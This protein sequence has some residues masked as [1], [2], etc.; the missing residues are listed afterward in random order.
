MNPRTAENHEAGNRPTSIIGSATVAS[1]QAGERAPSTIVAGVPNRAVAQAGPVV[2]TFAATG[3]R[4]LGYVA[5]GLLLALVAGGVVADPGANRGL[6]LIC[7]AGVLLTWVALVRPQVAAHAHGLLLRNMVRDTYIPWSAIERCKV[8]QTL[9]VVT[10]RRQFH[11]LG[12]SRSARSMVRGDQPAR[13]AQL[14]GSGGA[15]FL[16]SGGAA[17]DKAPN[18]RAN[19]EASGGIYTDYVAARILDLARRDTQQEERVDAVVA[20]DPVP[21]AA[22][23]VAIVCIGLLALL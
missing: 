20:W 1:A 14:L 9:Q 23:G 7:T 17:H 10:Q 22:C 2:E 4:V 16:G 11:G 5:G 3:G 8:N 19:E 6:I 12:V 18:R 13:G 15:G 21:L